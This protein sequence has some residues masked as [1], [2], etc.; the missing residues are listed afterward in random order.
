MDIYTKKKRWKIFLI[1]IAVT[2]V[3]V[4]LWYTNLLV[5]GVARDERKNVKIWADA[6]QRRA[7]LVNYTENFFQEIKEVEQNRAELLAET[8]RRIAVDSPSD[9]LTFYTNI[10]SNNKTIPVIMTSEEDEILFSTNVNFKQEDVKILD[11]D[12]KKE[13]SVYSPIIVKI[14]NNITQILYYKESRIFTELRLVLNDL[15]ESFF[16]EVVVNSASVPVIITDSTKTT[17]I[18]TG[19]IENRKASDS[20]Y[21]QKTIK[22]MASENTP[23]EID[24]SGQ[25]KTYIFYKDSYLLTQLRFYPYVQ[26]GI[27][28]LFLF[29]AY[30][31]FSTARKS[32]QNQ[33]WV[34]MSK[35]TAHQLGTPLSSLMAWLEL[36]RLKD[37][38]E[39]AISEMEK[40]INRLKTISERFS[41]IGSGTNLIEENIVKIIY[42]S[43]EY[44]KSRT[45]K[46]IKY[47]INIAKNRAII[48]PVNLH[49]FE[50]VIEN[51]CKN[52]VDAMSGKGEL[53][54]DI[55]EDEDSITIDFSDTGKGIPKSSF[56]AVFN[57][58]YT[59]KKRGWGLGLSLA[60]RIINDYHSGK[61]FVKSSAIDKGTTF[62]IVLKKSKKE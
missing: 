44:I 59:S 30:L 20:S 43:V 5:N 24:L 25:G 22:Q 2:I 14:S 58:G 61:I 37:A 6:I 10:I 18:I 9:D 23:I 50:W 35:E 19:N 38:D 11:E 51:I 36:L 56:K 12:L 42:D 60:K 29:I 31:L 40:D 34:G 46:N 32:E 27:I 21:L 47:H 55:S 4:S 28:G 48:V 1:A 33:V 16:S 57:P 62:R 54:V 13:F 41:K 7:K 26:F 17:I 8:Y 53:N 39:E 15:I 49:L 3:T 52:A 45:S